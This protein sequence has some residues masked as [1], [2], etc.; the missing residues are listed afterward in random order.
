MQQFHSHSHDLTE[1]PY[2][3]YVQLVSNQRCNKIPVAIVSD[4]EIGWAIQFCT[5]LFA[6]IL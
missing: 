6:H 3:G 1:K 5:N 4:D 2:L